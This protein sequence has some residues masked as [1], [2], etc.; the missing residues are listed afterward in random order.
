MSL[1]SLQGMMVPKSGG[2][3]VAMQILISSPYYPDLCRSTDGGLT[4][5]KVIMPI[6]P[7]AWG[8]PAMSDNGKYQLIAAGN[9]GAYYSTDYGATWTQVP[10]SL[11]SGCWNSFVSK[12]GQQMEIYSMANFYGVYSSNFGGSWSSDADATYTDFFWCNDART[13]LIYR[14][15]SSPYSL[16]YCP[17]WIAASEPNNIAT[18]YCP[19]V[20]ID[21][22]GQAIVY[23]HVNSAY[24]YTY[25]LTNKYATHFNILSG[26]FGS[27][28]SYWNNTIYSIGGD[29][30]YKNYSKIYST[31]YQ[32][33]NFCVTSD[34]KILF[35]TTANGVCYRS[36][37]SGV[38]WATVPMTL[39]SSAYT[40][41]AFQKIIV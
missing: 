35:A 13:Q 22:N 12:S 29:G 10:G 39:L 3:A 11:Y 19:V 5:S 34:E 4:F 23:S 8:N 40:R 6:T 41:T 18:V 30:L 38:T 36:T 15:S 26:N 32:A 7:S 1:P 9:S 37:D 14:H 25:Y 27:D 28:W 21:S 33:V 17:G 24:V 2:G 31:T 16:W 20:G